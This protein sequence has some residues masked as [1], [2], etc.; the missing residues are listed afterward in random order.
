MAFELKLRKVGNT[1][2]LILPKEALARMN[3]EE[4]DVVFLAETT[5]GGF[6][7]TRSNPKFAKKMK[8]AQ[9]LSRRYGNALKEVAAV[10]AS[11]EPRRF[12]SM[13]LLG[14]YKSKGSSNAK[15]RAALKS[16]TEVSLRRL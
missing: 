11:K 4:G 6:R 8:V 3:V 9:R 7:I 10:R 1:V 5:D 15:V 14:K 12:A 2:G 16:R 13:H